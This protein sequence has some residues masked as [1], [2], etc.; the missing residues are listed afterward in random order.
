MSRKSKAQEFINQGYNIN[1]TGKHV[2][3]TDAMK[4]YALDKISKIDRFSNRIIDV[5]VLMDIQKLEHRVDIVMKVEHIKIKST[6]ISNDMYVSIDRAVDRIKEQL[7][8]YKSRLHDHQ[9]RNVKVANMNVSV[10]KS[11]DQSVLDEANDD[12]ESENNRQTFESYAPH[13]IVA[14]ETHPLKTITA[15]EAVMK[16]D[17]SGDRFMVFRSEEDHKLKLIY[18]RTDGHYGLMEPE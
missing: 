5:Q 9:S 2:Q 12:I 15:A 17:L 6:G 7:L 14:T 10:I 8:K 3:I 4:D 11:F 1:I 18:R 16:M 13:H